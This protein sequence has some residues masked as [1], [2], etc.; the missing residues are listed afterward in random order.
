MMKLVHLSLDE[1][2][3]SCP[4]TPTHFPAEGVRVSIAE[5]AET[6]ARYA[7]GLCEAGIARGE[8]IGILCPTSPAFFFTLFGALRLGAAACPVPLPGLLTDLHAHAS[9]LARVLERGEVRT[10]VVAP[11]MMPVARLL[12]EFLPS[13]RVLAPD[14]LARSATAVYDAAGGGAYTAAVVQLTSGTTAEPKGAML[15][16]ENVLAA[17]RAITEGIRLSRSDVHCQWLPLFHDM[18]LF[19]A[20]AGVLNG[21]VQH[22]SPP[23]AFIRDPSSWLDRFARC[24]ATLYAG[25][26]FS[27]QHMLDAVD[28]DALATLDLSSWRIAFNGS[29]PV[30]PRTVT[31][32]IE[33]FRRAGLRPGVMF[34]VYGMA[35]A[36]LPVTFPRL[37]EEPVVQWVDAA[38]LA[39][40]RRALPV[41]EDH[42]RA[43]GLVSV[44]RP[45][46]GMTLRI[47]DERDREVGPGVV[48]EIQLSGP[49]I[50][51]GYDHELEAT[52]AALGEG[53]LRTGDLGY[54]SGGR[55]FIAGRLKELIVVRGQKFH[56]E[57]VEAVVRELP[58]V[59]RKRCAAFGIHLDGAERLAV[60]VEAKAPSVPGL[61]ERVRRELARTLGLGDVAVHVVRP[62]TIP[63]TASGKPQ[64]LGARHLLLSGAMALPSAGADDG[65]VPTGGTTRAQF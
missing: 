27:Y 16:H 7:A 3:S 36:T 37:G 13:V 15:S 45:V 32:F 12:L 31:R 33:H 2:A 14:D 52:R 60:V 40:E 62:G 19:G 9:G 54:V 8:R 46:T 58:D 64:R 42:P 41:A 29:E 35:E 43:R 5:M 38:V 56:P 23:S 63:H 17:V 28:D 18:G 10:L 47:V 11:K 39:S 22:L 20:L 24:R 53:W 57:T 25:P 44:G 1:V 30:S 34:P 65:A 50:M 55:L 48:G 61:V 21:F 4:D 49:S 6:S 51:L 59:N 26:N